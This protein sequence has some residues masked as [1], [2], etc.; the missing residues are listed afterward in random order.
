MFKG[1]TNYGENHHEINFDNYG[2][3]LKTKL[4]SNLTPNSA[5]VADNA[6]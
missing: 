3:W 1:G 6:A 4:I 2:K 5:L